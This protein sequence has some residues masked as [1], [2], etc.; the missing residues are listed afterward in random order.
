MTISPRAAISRLGQRLRQLNE[1]R[2]SRKEDPPRE[3][4]PLDENLEAIQEFEG[5]LDETIALID[6]E[7]RALEAGET[8][9]VAMYFKRKEE[10]LGLLSLREGAVAAFIRGE[11][12]DNYAI[13]E[14][15]RLLSGELKTNANLLS[16]VAS[17]S[18]TILAEVDRIRKRQSLEG[19]YDKDGLLRKDLQSRDPRPIKKI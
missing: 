6:L 10:L 13:K 8:A 5:L 9:R 14:K 16:G 1:N 2:R 19:V 7:N 11:H 3:P 15:L 18:H 17:A 4:V 12:P